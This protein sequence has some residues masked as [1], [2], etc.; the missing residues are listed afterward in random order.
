MKKS[1]CLA[2]CMNP[3]LQKT[4]VFSGLIQ[5]SVNRTGE[6][7]L[8]ASGKGVN[9]CRVLT[10]LGKEACH[11]TQLGGVLRP[12]FLEL[13]D[14]DGIKVEWVESA[15]PIRFCYTIIDKEQKTVTE[16]VEESEK[17]GNGTGE[18]LLESISKLIPDYSVLVISGTKANGFSDNLIPEMA[19]MARDQGCRVILD[20]RGKDLIKSLPFGPYLVK[21]NLYEF[22]STFEPGLLSEKNTDTVKKKV[23]RIWAELYE[24]YPCALV[25]TRGSE[26]LWYAEKGELAEFAFKSVE[27]LNTTGSG[28]AFSAGLAAALEEGAS[29]VDAVAEGARCGALNAALLKPGVIR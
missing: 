16:L 23:A 12:L 20:V 26:P 22:I 21:P 14:R 15:S 18:R 8:D 6:Y 1:S 5:D 2:V 29:L 24:K 19:H 17:V 7:R 10:Q 28:D 4:L 11:L 25:L 27:P 13:C 9:V 3:T